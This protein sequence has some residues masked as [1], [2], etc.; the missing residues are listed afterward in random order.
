VVALAVVGVPLI[1][2]VEVLKLTPAGSVGEMLY[3]NVPVPPEP[4]TGVKGR[5]PM[6]IV[7]DF[8]AI[9]VVAETGPLTVSWKVAEAV[10]LDASVT[11]TV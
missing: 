3:V 6:S 11:V 4:V 1:A 10:A 5:A 7:R 9:T 2:P 8:D